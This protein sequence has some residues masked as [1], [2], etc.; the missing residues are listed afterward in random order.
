[1]SIFY[2][3]T[4]AG[5]VYSLDC[6]ESFEFS[7]AG[8]LTE[9]AIESGAKVSDHYVNENKEFSLTGI[10]TDIKSSSSVN[11][12]KTDE[13]IAGLLAI[14]DSR[15]PFSLFYRADSTGE[16]QSF[17]NVVFTSVKFSQDAQVGY[18]RG[19]YAYKVALSMKQIIYANRATIGIEQVP[20]IKQAGVDKK[21][22][23]ASTKNKFIP[24]ISKLPENNQTP[25]G[26]KTDD[27]NNKRLAEQLSLRAKG[28]Q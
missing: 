1:M 14:K 21:S 3:L 8:S 10:I 28:A 19:L 2:I 9:Y 15:E 20:N 17:D 11:P 22:S 5:D 25:A 4:K 27:P 6:S 24:G 26:I 13:Y 23:N 18:A 16:Y 12:R 7:Q